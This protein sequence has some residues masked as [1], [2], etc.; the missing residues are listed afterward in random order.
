MEDIDQKQCLIDDQV[1]LLQITDATAIMEYSA[2]RAQYMKHG[3]GF[4]LVYNIYDRSTFEEIETFRNQIL[5][6]KEKDW[7]PVVVVGHDFWSKSDKD[8]TVDD[9]GR[10][11]ER[12]VSMEE[13]EQLAEELEAPFFEASAD[14][15]TNIEAIFYEL[16]RE[17]RHN[18]RPAAPVKD[19][20]NTAGKEEDVKTP[21]R[22][23]ILS[24]RLQAFQRSL[25]GLGTI[26]E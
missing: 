25:K 1:S 23:G 19:D 15:R 24:R 17:V 26:D 13:G 16:V 4:L 10:K 5:R 2:I 14:T 6:V 18:C 3:E 7:W 20:P 21:G 9:W 8:E 22:G 12:Q 11:K